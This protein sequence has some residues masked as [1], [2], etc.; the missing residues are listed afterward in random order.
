MVGLGRCR[1][2]TFLVV[3]QSQQGS[4]PRNQEHKHNCSVA[5]YFSLLQLRLQENTHARTHTP[6]ISLR[7]ISLFLHSQAPY[8]IR[9]H[10]LPPALLLRHSVNP[11]QCWT[12][13][14]NVCVCTSAG[15]GTRRS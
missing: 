7:E 3:I 12:D 13:V 11:V 14:C 9:P 5:H 15:A 6:N 2:N 1:G 10:F 8:L 4:E